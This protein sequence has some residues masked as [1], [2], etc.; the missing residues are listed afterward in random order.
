VTD[1]SH[2]VKI[3]SPADPTNLRQSRGPGPLMKA[4]GKSCLNIRME[5]IGGSC[6]N[7]PN[8]QNSSYADDAANSLRQS[9]QV[10][11]IR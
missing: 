7:A 11:P 5:V 1:I 2:P 6:I 9:Q 4:V 3:S 8:M 10:L